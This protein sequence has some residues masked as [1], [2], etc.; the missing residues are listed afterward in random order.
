MLSSILDW[1]QEFLKQ[2]I[3]CGGEDDFK[4]QGNDQNNSEEYDK[5]HLRE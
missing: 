4:D 3:K 2:V 5:G 1:L